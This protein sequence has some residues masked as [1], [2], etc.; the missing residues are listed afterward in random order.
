[1][2]HRAARVSKRPPAKH[3]VIKAATA[4]LCLASIA[5]AA[6]GV[7]VE[8]DGALWKVQ[9]SGFLQTARPARIVADGTLVVRGRATGAARYTIQLRIAAPNEAAARNIAMGLAVIRTQGNYV[10]FA[11]PGQVNVEIPSNTRMISLGSEEGSVDAADLDG[12]VSAQTLAGRVIVDRI[13]GNV[14]VRSNGGPVTLGRIGGSVRCLSGGG[15]IRAIRVNGEA[16]FES[17]GGDILVGEVRGQVRAVTEGGGIHIDQA[18][19]QVF[20]VTS[21]GPIAILNA[22]GQVTAQSSAGP[23]E[24]GT[25]PSVECQSGGGAIR[26]DNV[27]GLI[28]ATTGRGAIIVGIAS[29]RS[30]ADSF[31]TTSA[32]DIIIVLPSDMGVTVDAETIGTRMKSAIVSDYPGL[33]SVAG[34]TAVVARGAINGGGPTLRLRASGGRIEIRRK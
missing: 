22:L 13:G 1:M 3:T 21:G 2:P 8:R 20:A 9:T 16:V 28:R 5:G 25:A 32:G 23:I 27:T 7:V 34:R 11:G 18:G 26:L 14:E 15:T 31:L 30:L 33:Q 12:S 17:G 29:V 19:A 6:D 10:A 24:V 4:F